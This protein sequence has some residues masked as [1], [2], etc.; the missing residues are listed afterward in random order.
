MRVLGI[1]LAKGF[2]RF[3]VLEGTV[4]SPQ[5]IEKGK[6]ATVD[7]D[8]IPALMDW[9]ETQFRQL[10]ELYAADRI[11]YRLTLE[12]DKGMLA[13]SEFPLGVLNLIAHQKG[14][15]IAGYTKGSYVASKLG[16][17]KD[18]DIYAYCDVVFGKRPPYWDNNLKHAVLAAWFN[19]PK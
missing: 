4:S 17:G 19:L 18:Q 10:I 1:H 2:C 14:L 12:P 13:T 9:Y 3:A 16:L 6:L 7:P 5:L 15:E 8:N 11:S